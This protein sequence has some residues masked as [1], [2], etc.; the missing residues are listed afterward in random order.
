VETPESNPPDMRLIILSCAPVGYPHI[1]EF[2]DATTN[3]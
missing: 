2:F 1:P 3:K